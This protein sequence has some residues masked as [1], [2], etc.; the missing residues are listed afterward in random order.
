MILVKGQASPRRDAA[1]TT[2]P[3]DPMP[4]RQTLPARRRAATALLLT[5][6][7]LAACSGGTVRLQNTEPARQL[8]AERAAPL[9]SAY[10][11]WRVYQQRC[12]SCHRADA[13]GGDGVPDLR[14]RLRDIGP[15]R[16]VDLV[17]RRYDWGLPAGSAGSPRETLVDEVVA[18][19][20]G[21]VEMPAWQGEPVV[22]A[23]IM[24]LFEYLSARADGRIAGPEAPR[25]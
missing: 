23:H 9:G 14:L 1:R 13:S 20:R 25:R 8:A 6:V 19:E 3:A 22:G 7:L 4:A 5:A 12:A 21:A 24:D 10:A 17:L 11:G 18:R 2:T 16:F 15:Q